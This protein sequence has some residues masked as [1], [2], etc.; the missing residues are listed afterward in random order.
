M[1]DWTSFSPPSRRGPPVASESGRLDVLW[2]GSLGVAL[3]SHPTGL[4]LGSPEE[5][6]RWGEEL[7]SKLAVIETERGGRF[8][9]VV[10]VDG[11]NIRPQVADD[12][13]RV[14]RRY[15][16]RFASGLAR[17]SR[18]PNGVG[19]IITVAAMKEGYR[20]NLFTTR[21]EA[22]AHVLAKNDVPSSRTRF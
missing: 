5:V 6:E 9:I 2:D 8:P 17:Y 15:A 1:S 19:Q 12:Y 22:V 3:V 21:S 10:C 20:A 4:V 16:E 11:L 18:R 14:A 13:G 7:F